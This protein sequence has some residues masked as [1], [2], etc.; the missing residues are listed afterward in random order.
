MAKPG[1]VF[2]NWAGEDQLT[3]A[4]ETPNFL[5][6]VIAGAVLDVTA[7]IADLDAADDV[8][9]TTTAEAVATATTIA[10]TALS[11]SIPSGTILDFGAGLFARLTATA[12]AAATALTVEALPATIPI[13]STA[14]YVAA[15]AGTDGPVT[16]P[17]GSLVMRALVDA[18]D[19]P[20]LPFDAGTFDDAT[21]EAYLTYHG[22]YDAN[23]ID[24]V[25]LY[26]HQRVVAVNK[27]PGWATLHADAQAYIRAT[28]QTMN[29]AE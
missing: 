15:S 27:L 23:E 7:F 9:A 1:L 25:T 17:S 2:S 6:L 10:V 20:F 16:I 28:Y 21:H 4:K 12:A 18:D 24:E 13:A 22:I 11:G 19:G 3:W 29:A 26:R 14:T 8:V 5:N